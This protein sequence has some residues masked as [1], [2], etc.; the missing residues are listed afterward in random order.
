MKLFDEE[1]GEAAVDGSSGRFSPSKP[2]VH[3]SGR[4]NSPSVTSQTAPASADTSPTGTFA[5]NSDTPAPISARLM[6]PKWYVDQEMDVGDG[7]RQQN[8]VPD[9]PFSTATL[10]GGNTRAGVLPRRPSH[11]SSRPGERITQSRDP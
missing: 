2:E 11:L 1:D 5:M 7:G 9:Y 8:L 4:S 10:T 6:K 3:W